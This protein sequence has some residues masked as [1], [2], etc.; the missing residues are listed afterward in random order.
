MS[1]LQVGW[2][3]IANLAL[4]RISERQIDSIA[5]DD[6]IAERIRSFML[7]CALQVLEQHDWAS[8]THRLILP[9]MPEQPIGNFDRQ[10]E[11]PNDF[12]R[13]IEV[14]PYDSREPSRSFSEL[15]T[16]E[17]WICENGRILVGNRTIFSTATTDAISLAYVRYKETDLN[18]W[19][20]LLRDAVSCKIAVRLATNVKGGVNLA[21]QIEAE[22]ERVLNKARQAD[23]Y[24][25]G[26]D[27]H[28]YSQDDPQER[29]Y[30]T[31][32]RDLIR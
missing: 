31:R 12:V 30:A 4:A 6:E 29:A 22:Y 8:A 23:V 21:T 1:A 20:A 15:Q 14:I 25:Q 19:S 16:H 2:T 27:L 28:V 10:Y 24:R 11:L 17:T 5:Q 26:R 13:A 3:S 18:R 9:S 7:E 32:V